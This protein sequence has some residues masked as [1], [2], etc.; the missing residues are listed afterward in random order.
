[1]V[2]S[3][4]LLGK[5]EGERSIFGDC[6]I[7]ILIMTTVVQTVGGLWLTMI[8]KK[9]CVEKKDQ[10]TNYSLKDVCENK[11]ARD[12]LSA[13]YHNFFHTMTVEEARAYVRSRGA[14]IAGRSYKEYTTDLCVRVR[15]SDVIAG[16]AGTKFE[17][18]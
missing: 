6:K 5:P 9:A 7:Y 8:H 17:E 3:L 1:M 18:I 12:E 4:R 16:K 15:M 10:G 11:E 13:E 2:K 14:H